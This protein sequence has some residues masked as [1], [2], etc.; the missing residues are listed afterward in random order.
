MKL[1]RVKCIQVGRW[2]I[3][4]CFFRKRL[5]TRDCNVLIMFTGNDGIPKYPTGGGMTRPGG[6]IYLCG[7]HDGNQARHFDGELAQL[8]LFDSPLTNDEVIL[9]FSLLDFP[10]FPWLFRISL[11]P[12]SI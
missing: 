7:R 4:S 5:P 3:D 11:S 8:A 2:L 1:S 12:F 6:K 9:G 10:L